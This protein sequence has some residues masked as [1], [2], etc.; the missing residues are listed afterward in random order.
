MPVSAR[1]S[2]ANEPVEKI[3]I[4]QDDV[5][6]SSENVCQSDWIR[7]R[8][9]VGQSEF[10]TPLNG[11]ERQWT[12]FI[13]V[14]QGQLVVINVRDFFDRTRRHTSRPSWICSFQVLVFLDASG[15]ILVYLIFQAI[16]FCEGKKKESC[17]TSKTKRTLP[18]VYGK[19]ET[20]TNRKNFGISLIS[21]KIPVRL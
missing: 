21:G 15:Q 2:T 11:N 9:G 10:S 16:F 17:L 1:I 12:Y 18:D 20:E 6:Q 5:Q 19:Q 8:N 7:N 14:G 3:A 13:A 4:H